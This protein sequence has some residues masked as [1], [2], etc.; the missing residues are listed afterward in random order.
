MSNF[1]LGKS[2]RR[3]M[4]MVDLKND[5]LFNP[6]EVIIKNSPEKHHEYLIQQDPAEIFTV[7]SNSCKTG[8]LTAAETIDDNI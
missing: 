1:E 4:S 3:A 6:V 2:K 8:E 5:Q 7:V